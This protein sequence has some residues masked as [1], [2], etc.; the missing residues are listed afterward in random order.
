MA[1]NKL[2]SALHGD[3]LLAHAFEDNTGQWIGNTDIG[4]PMQS[5]GKGLWIAANLAQAL[6]GTIW[7]ISHSH[8][9]AVSRAG[10]CHTNGLYYPGTIVCCRLPV[11]PEATVLDTQL[12]GCGL[13]KPARWNSLDGRYCDDDG[14]LW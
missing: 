4:S 11:P 8:S 3:E 14:G 10:I 5:G 13:G 12:Y 1:Q 6:G 2:Y 7:C 9:V